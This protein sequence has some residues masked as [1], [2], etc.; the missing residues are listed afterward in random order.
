M[1]DQR[2]Y[3]TAEVAALLSI[4]RTTVFE[5]CQTGKLGHLRIGRAIRISEAGLA[6]YISSRHHGPASTNGERGAAAPASS[7]PDFEDED[8]PQPDPVPPPVK[9]TSSQR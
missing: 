2:Y 5:L 9:L 8:E 6:K 3:T 1:T 7:G 4:C